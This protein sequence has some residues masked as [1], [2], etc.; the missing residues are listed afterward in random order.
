MVEDKLFTPEAFSELIQRF[1]FKLGYTTPSDYFPN[2]VIDPDKQ[3]IHCNLPVLGFNA[4]ISVIIQIFQR[5][6]TPKDIESFVPLVGAD[7]FGSEIGIM[8][9]TEKFEK[10]TGIAIFNPQ[11]NKFIFMDGI[12]LAESMAKVRGWDD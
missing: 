8:I 7:D 2:G 6:I 11:R 5:N 4:E 1:V 10:G 3:Y 12:E 9:T